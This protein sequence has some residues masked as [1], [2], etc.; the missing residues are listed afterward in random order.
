MEVADL[1][2]IDGVQDVVVKGLSVTQVIVG[3]I[4]KVDGEDL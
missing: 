4:L 3:H 2:V 1:A